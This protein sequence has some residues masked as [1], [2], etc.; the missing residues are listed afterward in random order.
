MYKYFALIIF[1]ASLFS[2]VSKKDIVYFQG[3]PKQS[4]KVHRIHNI[5]YKLQV[6]DN[7]V[8]NII[9]ADQALVSMFETGQGSEGS[10]GYF[11]GFSINNYGNI[12]IPYL[13]EINVLGFTT[14]EVRIKLEE[15]FIKY[16]NEKDDVFIT[17]KL[18]G[19][20]YTV[21]GEIGSPGTKSIAQNSLNIIE[22][23]SN[24]GDITSFGNRK[25][26]QVIR[27]SPTGQERFVIDLTKIEA[28]NSPIFYI[29]SNDI[30]Q[31]LPLPQK[32]LE[33]LTT[34]IKS[35]STIVSSISLLASIFIIA[36]NL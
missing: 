30:I 15:E 22:A 9:S 27:I 4:E 19:I 34:G 3:T 33:T 17:V 31:V 8:I 29:K 13:G 20:K 10:D 28:F 25:K 16:F 1:T 36:K 12:R 32:S 23:I 2:C 11:S 5:P 26:V 21:I 18:S 35:L 14:E 7:I 6:N 24:S